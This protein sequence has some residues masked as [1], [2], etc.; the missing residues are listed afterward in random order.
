MTKK[1]TYE[2]VFNY[3]TKNKCELLSKEYIN[4]KTK[5]S[6][7]CEKNHIV[8]IRFNDFYRGYRCGICYGKNNINSV[9]QY[10]KKLNCELL[11]TKYKDVFTKMKYRCSC[12]NIYESTFQN[13]KSADGRC[14]QCGINKR[15]DTNKNKTEEEIEITQNKRIETNLKKY[16]CENPFGN[17]EIQQKIKDT[18]LEKYGCENPFSNKDIIEIIKE[19]N[20]N[21]TE[22]E[23]EDIQNKRKE[24]NLD[25]YG[26]ECALQN[27]DIKNKIK[28]TNIE[29][30][31]VEY[32]T[33]NID[34]R[35]KI[36]EVV[37]D[38]YGVE[39]I[40]QSEDIKNKIK[41]TNIE[42]YGVEY[43]IQNIDIFNKLQKS[44]YT[45]KEYTMPSGKIITCQGYEPFALDILLKDFNEEH[46]VTETTLI[47]RIN[48]Q[49]DNKN[50]YYFPDIYLPYEQKIIEVKSDYTYRINLEKNLKKQKATLEAGYLFEFWIFDKDKI[51][52][53]LK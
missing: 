12:G 19:T 8:E 14:K 44:Q 50:H 47:P 6:Y 15:K 24:T 32:P 39:N 2:F 41:N 21:K 30:L 34:V 7:K 10:Y 29:N 17:K 16:G 46:I 23:K 18:N 37:L 4:V 26:F 28:N 22:E 20:K 53:I 43:P 3:F 13:F 31:G 11:E 48:Y 40:L 1:F 27:E 35:N 33:Q 38:K 25:K 52:T 36:K 5:L 42:K 51:L 49:L 9:K 45:L